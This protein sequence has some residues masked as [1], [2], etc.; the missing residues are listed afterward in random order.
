M[1]K[2]IGSLT[3]AK[4]GL[5]SA[6]FIAPHLALGAEQ[7]QTDPSTTLWYSQPAASWE[8]EALPIG[9]GRLGAMI[10]G[11]VGHER[12][13]INEESVWSG[14]RKNWNRENAS[15]NLPKIRE[16][17]L[18][19]KND[20]AEALVN[21]TFTCTGGGSKGGA[22]GPWG[23]FQ[24]LGNLRLVWAS[25]V[26]GLP[27]NDWKIQM[28]ETPG[29]TDARKQQQEAARLATEAVKVETD[30]SK[31]QQYSVSSGKAVKGTRVFQNGDRAVLRH[32]LELTKQ[33]L[34]GLGMLR[35]SSEA[36]NG[37]VYINGEKAGE[38]HGWQAS[39]HDKFEVDIRSL[40]KPGKN[41][42]AIHCS[43]YRNRGQLPVSIS[44]DPREDVEHYRRS[45]DLREAV[46]KVEYRRNGVTYKREA[47]SS[48]PD[49]VMVFRFTAD[50]GQK[51]SFT[52]ALDRLANFETRADGS[53][54][55]LMTGNTASGQENV[56]GMKF[57]A[58][59]K[60]LNTGG[61]VA[62]AGG[63]LHVKSADEVVLLVA[64]ATNYQGFA[65]RNTADPIQATAD[66]IAKAEK[67][68][69][70]QL[71]AAHIAE[72]RAFY[73]RV[74]LNL[75][76]GKDLGLLPTDQRLAALAKGGTDPALDALY[77]NFG[78]H[79]LISSSRPGTMPA[80][81]QGIWAEG[82]QTPWNGDY[83][84][85]INVQMNYWPAEVTGLGE[86]HTPLFKLIESLQKPGAE[87]AKAYY[88][89]DGWVAHVITN[90]WGFTAPGEQ[91][92]WGATATGSPWL[93][94]HLWEHYDYNR[95]KEY[96]KWA[97]PIMKGSAEFFLDMLI[98]DPKT[99]LLVTA[100]SN[101]PENT[102]K[103]ADGRTARVCM[104]PTMDNQILRELFDNCIKA[105]EILGIDEAFRKQL[106]ETRAKLPPNRIG[107]HGQI[108]EWLEDY[109][110]PEINHRHV[111]HL[112]GLHP[113]DE[114]T[115]ES[116]PELAAAAKVSLQRRGDASTG[117]SMAWKSNFWARLHDGNHA[118]K[119]L[120]MLITKGGNNLFCLHPPF[121]IDG[122][123]GGTAAIAEMLLQSHGGA[124]HLL[125][126]LPD[127]WP[128]GKVTGLRARGGYEV[129]IEWKDGKLTGASIRGISNTNDEVVVRHSGREIRL[130]VA[131]G[132]TQT[133]T[134]SSFR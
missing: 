94:D 86:C 105:S 123:F 63:K 74:S 85:D 124:I 112:Y 9:N 89:A 38:L 4:L 48:A 65:G 67:K 68:S 11:G 78:R 29:I 130:K 6:V 134:A 12:I 23:C 35:I 96:L 45:L 32:H 31:W 104:G 57:V 119:L 93:C 121:Q 106:T 117:W 66:D 113:H 82:L 103:M 81:L 61:K 92:G 42:I 64:A 125:P 27:L 40:L 114:I 97:Y 14:S 5:L 39:G 77:F 127:V 53:A 84:I 52:A 36:R 7:L 46:S 109:D 115:P 55:L 20:E 19:G 73:D 131:K 34:D 101:S 62:V 108:M 1:S 111:S 95:D 37:S 13:A 10:F 100:P 54:G 8:R 102:L 87:T 110:E 47:F 21:Q 88:N 90:I 18:A 22:R 83:H 44:L 50:K 120:T 26:A 133:V 70:D 43:S 126:A 28:I 41:L 60:A 17:L 33:Q 80:N 76:D 116:T 30:D 71:R 56:E 24:E 122:N 79:L 15:A 59:L 51:I 107:K 98:T 91:A 49:Q 118:H 129:D 75:G 72:Y 132:C 16:L 69:Y 25:D 3:H 99:G 58:R 2:T 128:D